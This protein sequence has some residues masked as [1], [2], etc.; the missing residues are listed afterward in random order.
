MGDEWTI[1]ILKLISYSGNINAECVEVKEDPYWD[2]GGIYKYINPIL[3]N[4][5]NLGNNGFRNVLDY[6]NT[7]IEKLSI[8]EDMAQNSLLI[9]DSSIDGHIKLRE[10]F[11][12]SDEGK[13]ELYSF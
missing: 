5:I 1:N 2:C 6:G 8:E 9:I 7:Y 11:N 3:Y 4:Q 13:E 10:H 12:L